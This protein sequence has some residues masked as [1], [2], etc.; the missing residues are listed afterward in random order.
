MKLIRFDEFENTTEY[1]G[2][3][4]N[5][6]LLSSLAGFFKGIFDW[7]KSPDKLSKAI[8]KAAGLLGDKTGRLDP[9]SVNISSTIFLTMSD[10]D[11]K[12]QFNISMTKLGDLPNDTAIF[13]IVGT[14]NPAMLKALVGSSNIQDLSNNSVMAILND[15]SVSKG[16]P[17][18]MRIL[19]NAMPGGQDY[20]TQ[21]NLDS[22]VP[23]D[24]VKKELVG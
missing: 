13:Q 18:T 1:A 3:S 21:N 6:G 15:K 12:N 4:I 2:S 19:K 24:A 23:M 7:Y 10:K 22:V 14:T 17:V 9:A 8:D 16:K 20:V 11:G 5:E